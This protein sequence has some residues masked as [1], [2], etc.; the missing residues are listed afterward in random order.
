MSKNKIIIDG[1]SLTLEQIEYFLHENPDIAL[2]KESVQKIK[3][4]R[5]LVEKWVSREESIYGVTTGFGEFSNV[6]ISKENIQKL[7]ENLILSHAVGCGEN[8]P[9]MI[10]KIMM[11]LRL[12]ALAR[13]YSGIRLETLELLIGMM[14]HNIIP[15]IPSQ[16]SVGSSGDLVQLS[17]LVL[18]M[19]GRGRVQLVKDVTA[20]DAASEK[21]I[22]GPSG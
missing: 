21:I 12:N 22:S 18:A 11:L 9:P 3:K 8:L 1:K 20:D 4:S 2:S 16:G 13:G 19:I 7:Q 17:H 5:A 6:R 10:V 14:K 15:V